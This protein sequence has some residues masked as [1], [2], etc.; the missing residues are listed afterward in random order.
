MV[1]GNGTH[2]KE[3]ALF[4]IRTFGIQGN[5]NTIART[6]KLVKDTL[7]DGY[8]KEDIMMVIEYL[9]D[10]KK[11]ELYSFGYV[12]VSIDAFL[13]D[14]RKRQE[15]ID[16]VGI[17]DEQAKLFTREVVTLDESS[18]RNRKKATELGAESRFRKKFDFNLHSKT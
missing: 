7:A 6:V 18:E 3:I 8:S 5:P 17:R 2:A 13:K 14:A 11:M 4:F 1:Q 10:V 16:S 15:D 12:K 9:A